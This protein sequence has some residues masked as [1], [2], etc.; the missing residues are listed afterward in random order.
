MIKSNI[1]IYAMPVITLIAG[2][3]VFD[4]V[5]TLMAIIGMVLVISGMLMANGRPDKDQE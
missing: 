2:H 5:I 4:E 1:F 3:F